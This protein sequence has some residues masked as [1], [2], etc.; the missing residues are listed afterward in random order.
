[1]AKKRTNEIA[2]GLTV[3][4]TLLL[5]IFIV[6]KLGNWKNWLQPKQKIE[7]QLPYKEGL[8]GLAKGSPVFLGGF[9]IGS[10]TKAD[11]KKI[12]SKKGKEEVWVYFIME[13][14]ETYDLYENCEL[15]AESNM[16][17]GQASLA[18][19]NLGSKTQ[20][21]KLLYKNGGPD[22]LTLDEMEGGVTEIVNSIRKELDDTDPG[23]LMHKIKHELSREPNS[24]VT[25]LAFAL[26]NFGAVATNINAQLTKDDRNSLIYRIQEIAD[27]FARISYRLNQQLELDES[28]KETLMTKLHNT[29]DLLNTSLKEIETLIAENKTNVTETIASVNKTAKIL[30]QETIPKVNEAL[31]KAQTGLDNLNQLIVSAKGLLEVNR[32]S[33]SRIVRNVNEISVNLKFVSREIL[34]A[35]WKLIY[36]P[37]KEEVEFQTL[38]D[39]AAGFAAAA[40]RLDEAS[41]RL[42]TLLKTTEGNIALDQ[43]LIDLINLAKTDLETSRQKY[44]KAEDIFWNELK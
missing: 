18:I 5:T 27:N 44:K 7:V 15:A 22:T 19:R 20:D 17:G 21:S 4:V 12:T 13:I 36:K 32:E 39:A 40:E 43:D 31:T 10:V 2:V 42:D 3:L 33:V 9:K 14:P 38:V 1:M 26:D 8:K 11:V 30:E 6:V 29:L 25:S 34:R 28:V 41:A 37:T 24:I 23:S 35:P 16:L